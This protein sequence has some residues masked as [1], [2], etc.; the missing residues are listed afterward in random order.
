MNGFDLDL[1]IERLEIALEDRSFEEL[2]EATEITEG[3]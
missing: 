2:Q 3:L 1:L